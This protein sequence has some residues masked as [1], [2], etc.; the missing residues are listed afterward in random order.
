MKAIE[1]YVWIAYTSV[2]SSL[3]YWGEIAARTIFMSLILYVFLQLWTAVYAG[4]GKDRLGGLTLKQMLWY[5]M[6]TE[7][8]VLSSPRVSV[9]VDEDV[10]TGRLAVQLIRPL[11]YALS[12]MAK[13]LAE[14]FVRFTVNIVS[15]SLVT[16]LLVGP[17]PLN[18]RGLGMFLMVVP[19][20][21]VL[22]FLGYLFIGL[23]AFW[24]E[25]TVGLWLLY[26]RL[27]M[28]L[29]GMLMPIEVFPD[30]WQPILRKLPFAMMVYG[31]AR[32]FVAPDARFLSAIAGSQ[33]IGLAA[34]SI[35]VYIIQSMGLRR[36]QS[37]GG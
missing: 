13:T 29:G 31:P 22:D 17:I 35:A 34:F 4:A 26:S 23:F 37:N 2:R 14:R 1:K 9:E 10:R 33:V 8:F 24:L 28:L 25:S 12:L 7:A 16:L 3:A 15:G 36:I 32:M 30:S 11:S 18:A 21:F 6:I 5:V 27:T 19:L 20:A